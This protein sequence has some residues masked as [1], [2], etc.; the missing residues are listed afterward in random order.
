VIVC[1]IG[2][3]YV[4]LKIGIKW[5]DQLFVYRLEIEKIK[6]EKQFELD[7]LQ[8]I[9]NL[10]YED[11]DRLAEKQKMNDQNE[12][13]RVLHE[14]IDDLLK[15][16]EGYWRIEKL[17]EDPKYAISNIRLHAQTAISYTRSHTKL[18]GLEFATYMENGFKQVVDIVYVE[19]EMK[20]Q[21]YSGSA[22]APIIPFKDEDRN[23]PEKILREMLIK[24]NALVG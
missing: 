23:K 19:W 8:K 18:L 21:T 22:Y 2:I 16:I 14:M 12:M 4:I 5:V 1:T 7:K 15:D 6:A 11:E 20:H 9:A 3:G 24:T 17:Q 13:V 10:K